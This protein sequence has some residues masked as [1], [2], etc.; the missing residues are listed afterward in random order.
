[1]TALGKLLLERDLIGEQQLAASIQRQKQLGGRL[2]TCLLEL[3]ALSEDVLLGILAEQLEVPAAD[4]EDLRDIP[5]EVQGLLPANLAISCEAIPFRTDGARVDVAMLEVHNLGLQDELSFVIGKPLRVHIANEAR[6]FEALRRFY[7]KDCSL[8]FSHLIDRLNRER[9]EWRRAPA[10]PPAQPAPAPPTA[11]PARA[12]PPAATKAPTPPRGAGQRTD[13]SRLAYPPQAAQQRSIPLTDEERQALES[14]RQKDQRLR[15]EPAPTARPPAPRPPVA[16]VEAQVESLF[17]GD[18]DPQRVAAIL[19]DSV[20]EE[21]VRTLLF[22]VQRN[23]VSGWMARGPHIDLERF[24]RFSVSLEESS[25]FRSLAEGGNLYI[26][27][28]SPLR[29]H[30]DLL[31]VWGGSPATECL[32]CSIPIRHRIV[33]VLYG[34]RD[35]LGVT[36]VNLGRIQGL[37]GEAAAALQACILRRKLSQAPPRGFR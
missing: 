12:T 11:P 37:C 13:A 15:G 31:S 18:P 35:S 34:D 30:L 7:G 3:G 10:E 1:M 26:G 29:P 24:G 19:L 2:G 5:D 25:V 9:D 22:R 33:A 14:S 27:T 20:A 32:L 36:G 6:I 16:A 23:R 17:K 4:I 21:F 8:R 28:L